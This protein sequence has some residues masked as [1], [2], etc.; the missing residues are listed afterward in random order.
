[1]LLE[2]SQVVMRISRANE[3]RDVERVAGSYLNRLRV[4]ART[5]ALTL[6][7]CI[8]EWV[9]GIPNLELIP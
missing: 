4:F 7:Y 3:P 2:R 6:V 8:S 5:V 1:V 9:L